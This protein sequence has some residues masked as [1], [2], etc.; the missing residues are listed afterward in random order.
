M[1]KLDLTLQIMNQTDNFLNDKNKTVIGLIKSELGRKIIK[2]FVG[3]RAKTYSY[4][5][6][7][8]SEN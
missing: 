1:L 4:L 3:L 8:V 5:I 2:K 7:E 6:D